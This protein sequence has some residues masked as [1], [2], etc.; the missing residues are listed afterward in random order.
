[1]RRETF[2]LSQKELQR[3][4]KV[5]KS[6]VRFE[7]GKQN[8]PFES[9]FQIHNSPAGF[10]LLGKIGILAILETAKQVLDGQIHWYGSF[11]RFHLPVRNADSA[12]FKS[13]CVHRSD[14]SS[15]RRAPVFRAK[16][17]AP[18]PRSLARPLL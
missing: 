8:S 15:P 5:V 4:A 16:G 7:L 12:L 2:H 13:T 3:V 18:V 17:T 14:R 1:M 9:L 11:C 6:E 10:R